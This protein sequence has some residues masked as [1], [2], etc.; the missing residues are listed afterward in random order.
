VY[1][2]GDAYHYRYEGWEYTVRTAIVSMI[3]VIVLG[4]LSHPAGNAVAV[5]ATTP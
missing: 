2:L 5:A 4:F 3:V 1:D